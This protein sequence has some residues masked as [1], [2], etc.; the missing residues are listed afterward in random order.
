MSGAETIAEAI[1]RPFIER[2]VG[3]ALHNDYL[4]TLSVPSLIDIEVYEAE[5]F[6]RWRNVKILHRTSQVG[7][8]GSVKLQ[9]RVPDPAIQ[10]LDA[11]RMPQHLAL[12]FAAYLSCLAPLE[13]FDPGPFA[14]EIRDLARPKLQ[15]LASGCVSGRKLARKVFLQ[16][17]IFDQ[18][19][20]AYEDFIDRIGF[21]IDAIR[22]HGVE[23]AAAEAYT[24][25]AGGGTVEI[26]GLSR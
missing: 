26:H 23:T 4:P 6:Q 9:Q 20:A 21:Y 17:H 25:G 22:Y 7:T 2:A 11:G 12:T 14:A 15:D 3:A 16:S 10:H 19:L 5:L 13:G 24:A 18:R 1:N 8:D